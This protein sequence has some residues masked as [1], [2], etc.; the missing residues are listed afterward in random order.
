MYEEHWKLKEKPFESTA[1]P[2]FLYFSAQHEEGY[3]RLSYAVT[4]NKGCAVMTGVFGCGKTVL[5]QAL[6]E[7]LSRGQ[8]EVGFVS[9]PQ[10]SNV[11][12]LREILYSLGAREN[13]PSAKTDILHRLDEMFHNNFDNG[14]QTVIF[15]D[16]AHLIDDRLIY[17]ELRLLLNFQQNG[18]FLLTLLLIG[19]PD[20]REKVNA[21]KQFSQRV[22]IKF[23]L[24][25]LDDADTRGYVQHRLKVAGREEPLFE[26]KALKAVYQ[27]SGGI[28]RRINQIC[29]LA[30]LTGYGRKVEKIDSDIIG[31]V[32]KDL[33]A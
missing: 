1:D 12:L 10:L 32:V 14:K 7:D 26:D 4:E 11:E 20:L 9:N 27:E 17:E 21:I 31:E 16:E 23:H 3:T 29:D 6:M 24:G 18:R 30:L 19:Q 2:R 13:L 5:A 15:V 25:P 8:Y 22:A 28:P 33:E